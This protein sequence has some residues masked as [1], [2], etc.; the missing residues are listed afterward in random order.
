MRIK[1]DIPITD[2]SQDFFSRKPLVDVIVRAIREYSTDQ[3]NCITIGIYGPWGEGK[4]SIMNMVYSRLSQLKYKDKLTLVKYNPWLIKDQESLL[5]DFF[6]TI[7]GAGPSKK[8]NS[9]LKRYAN[10]ISY[11][12]GQASEKIAPLLGNTVSSLFGRIINGLPGGEQSVEECK[13]SISFQLKKE[14]RHLIVF[15]DDLDRLDAQ[16]IHTVF[17]LIKQ[18]AD[19]DNVIYLVAIDVQRVTDVLEKENNYGNCF[20]DKIIQI[21]ITLPKLQRA[22]LF[23]E[24]KDSLYD[25]VNEFDIERDKLDVKHISATIIDLIRNQR[26]IIRFYNALLLLMPSVKDELNLNDFCILEYLNI[27]DHKIYDAIY[28]ERVSLLRLHTG[29]LYLLQGSDKIDKAVEERFDK[30][31]NRITGNRSD[32]KKAIGEII[33]NLFPKN[34]TR[35]SFRTAYEVSRI[36][37]PEYFERYFIRNYQIGSIPHSEVARLITTLKDLNEEDISSIIRRWLDISDPVRTFEALDSVIKGNDNIVSE[38]VNRIIS[39]VSAIFSPIIE[40]RLYFNSSFNI[41]LT[42]SIV[43]WMQMY[44]HEIDNDGNKKILEEDINKVISKIFEKG[45]L[46]LCLSFLTSFYRSFDYIIKPE[47]FDILKTRIIPDSERSFD[48]ILTFKRLYVQYFFM[49]WY[50]ANSKEMDDTMKSWIDNKDFNTETFIRLFI[51][52]NKHFLQD[53]DLFVSLFENEVEDFMKNLGERIST[54]DNDLFIRQ[55][56]SNWKVTLSNYRLSKNQ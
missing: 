20:I 50:N 23:R 8:L 56:F 7:I 10:L 49:Y 4:T 46:E 52:S 12:A 37:N 31:I 22:D 17:R 21:P 55:L 45:E 14:K 5:I 6:K 35:V 36:C 38:R 18:V 33:K 13:H 9:F 29:D 48:K 25:L 42:S 11:I 16:E 44:M 54:N 1:K 2:E 34:K 43:A 19:F 47:V 15:I 24:T 28:A 27:Y 3:T 32:D 30:S 26:D 40:Q 41:E 39:L 53:L 51:D